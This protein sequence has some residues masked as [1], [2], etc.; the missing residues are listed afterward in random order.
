MC[1]QITYPLQASYP[2]REEP[3]K[4]N[5]KRDER[6]K[7][8]ELRAQCDTFKEIPSPHLLRFLRVRI[9]TYIIA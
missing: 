7:V 5:V 1:K 6:E 2:W 3:L 9:Y 4:S 8:E